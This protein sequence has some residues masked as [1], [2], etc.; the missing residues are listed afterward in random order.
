M[1]LTM[2]N[3]INFYLAYKTNSMLFSDQVMRVKVSSLKEDASDRTSLTTTHHILRAVK[4]WKLQRNG[5]KLPEYLEEEKVEY[6]EKEEV[7]YFGV[8]YLGVET[9]MLA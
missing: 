1:L 7:N 2:I 3:S 9:E 8:D 5:G 4:P 6:L